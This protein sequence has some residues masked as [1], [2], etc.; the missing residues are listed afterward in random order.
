MNE[1]LDTPD[2]LS[3]FLDHELDPNLEARLFAQ[4]AES[5]ELRA[6]LRT[7]QL[8]QQATRSY[9]S[10]LTAPLTATSAVFST[11]GIQAPT[12]AAA[13]GVLSHITQKLWVPV[14]ISVLSS[15]VTLFVV[16]ILPEWFKSSSEY[17]SHSD[18]SVTT[19]E[20]DVSNKSLETEPSNTA[21]KQVRTAN[22][23]VT[24][25]RR[26]DATR[27]EPTHLS[28]NSLVPE[29]ESVTSDAQDKTVNLVYPFLSI[30][31]VEAQSIGELANV[32]SAID[33]AATVADV[34][35]ERG[36]FFHPV[37]PDR[38]ELHLRSFETRASPAN[39]VP[40]KSNP[41]FNQM[42]IGVFYRLGDAQ[43]LGIEVGQEAFPQNYDGT[44]HGVRVR[45]EQN[46]LTPWLTAVY[47]HDL[48]ELSFID[49]NLYPTIR[50]GIGITRERW[51]ITRASAGL[52][53]LPA[54]N[55]GLSVG[56]E[57]AMLAYSFQSTWFTTR[58]AGIVYGITLHF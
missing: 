7:M 54:P 6:Q 16:L 45:Y 27:N 51:P 33:H 4:L 44:E 2:L 22:V 40:T 14:T 46:L 30:Q 8:I 37:L 19:S 26:R 53:W 41:W 36:I 25:K 50:F 1:H 5:S 20:R 3:A 55:V 32:R 15:L 49:D 28:G 17:V 31:S 38:W 58:K 29:P 11:L 47:N 48:R 13:V 21:D 35:G 43:K 57:G 24:E 52:L 10:S 18:S 34:S 39:D 23:T 56:V 42:A 9:Q 12:H